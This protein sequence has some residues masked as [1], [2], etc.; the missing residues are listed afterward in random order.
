MARK[1]IPIVD[2]FAGPGGLGEG[3]MSVCDE[4]GDRRF[5]IRL[6][7]EME[8]F[9]H[10]TLRLRTFLRQFPRGD[11][12]DGYYEVL[13][14]RL[15]LADL[16]GSYPRQTK[17]VNAI[18][19]RAK[20][21]PEGV[22]IAEVRRRVAE[23]LGDVRDWVL[24][25]GPPCQ[26][27]SLV[28]RS[29]NRGVDDYDPEKDPKQRLYVEYLQLIADRWPAVFVMENVKGLLSAK[30]DNESVFA[31][32][33][34]DL[35]NPAVAVREEE[36]GRAHT[37]RRHSYNIYSLTTRGM[38]GDLS[39]ADFVVRCERYGIPQARHRVILL[40]VRDDITSEPETLSLCSAS[41]TV[42]D[43]IGGLPALRSGLSKESDGPDE[44][45]AAVTRGFGHA[46]VA[47]VRQKAGPNV[48]ARLT[49]ALSGLVKPVAGRGA[50]FVESSCSVGF[51]KGWFLDARLKGVCNH[52]TRGHIVEDLWRYIYA[53]CYGEKKNH[54]PELADF[55]ERLLPAHKNA[56]KALDGSLFADRFRVQL[57]DKPATTVVSHIAKDGHYYI[58]PEP[59]QCRSLT[60]R[61]A[62]RLQTFPDNYFFVGPRTSQY[63]QV[64]NAVPPLLARQIA[65]IVQSILTRHAA[66]P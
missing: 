21:G 65:E 18:S 50:E 10:E 2:L 42:E 3:F 8:Q 58:H 40:G 27:Y 11:A 20:L 31:H 56:T 62:A 39:P 16:Y 63:T 15:S 14:G 45:I 46:D 32:I 1:P 49:C 25:G 19:W 54:S 28:G 13:R 34:K 33:L 5:D 38:F 44:W 9:A 7:V 12:P 29:R 64:G 60:V 35:C 51:E 53:A 48:A 52:S 36:R 24:I 57:A 43:A 66:A 47:E 55:P 37:G 26:A 30:L 59:E 4:A 23:R 17:E 6:S 61:E 22:P 41:P